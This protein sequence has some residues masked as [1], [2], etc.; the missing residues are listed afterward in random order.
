MLKHRTNRKRS[1]AACYSAFT[2]IEL[3]VV[4]AIIG[5]LAAILLPALSRAKEKARSI[6]CLSNVRQITLPYKMA[7]LDSGSSQMGT[8]EVLDWWLDH[9]GLPNE[10]WICPD[11]PAL[12]KPYIDGFGTVN[13]AWFEA[14]WKSASRF[15]RIDAGRVVTPKV[16]VGSYGFNT[17][18]F[19]GH[20]L[21]VLQ[22]SMDTDKWAFFGENDITHPILTPIVADS[23]LDQ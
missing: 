21:E 23:V 9:V 5:I 1:F 22:A 3:L 6:K 16:R 19:G 18:L 7:W 11:A 2:L 20:Q 13:Q 17:C 14:D 15:L 12:P 10:G 4:M 8:P